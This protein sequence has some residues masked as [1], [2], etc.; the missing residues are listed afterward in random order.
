MD[1]H[2]CIYC[3][4]P[5]SD[6]LHLPAEECPRSLKNGWACPEPEKHHRYIPIANVAEA[7]TILKKAEWFDDS[8]GGIKTEMI[9]EAIEILGG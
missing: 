9:G 2:L 1:A 6:G 8:M 4:K 5:E 3:G 7:I